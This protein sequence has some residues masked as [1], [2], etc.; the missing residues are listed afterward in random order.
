MLQKKHSWI[1]L[2][3][4]KP[5]GTPSVNNVAY[6]CMQPVCLSSL[7]HHP[8]RSGQNHTFYFNPLSNVHYICQIKVEENWCPRE[9]PNVIIFEHKVL[10]LQVNQSGQKGL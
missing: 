5:S 1:A 10:R 7:H 2:K 3:T 6:P 8:K 4:M 9:F